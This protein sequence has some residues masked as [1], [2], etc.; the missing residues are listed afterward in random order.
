MESGAM[1]DCTCYYA[2]AISDV[3]MNLRCS[4]CKLMSGGCAVY[5]GPVVTVDD[6][7]HRS[8]NGWNHRT[9]TRHPTSASTDYYLGQ[10]TR[11]VDSWPIAIVCLMS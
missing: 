4:C 8:Q 6:D 2:I 5:G 11:T 7:G 10:D 3:I 1:I 9:Y